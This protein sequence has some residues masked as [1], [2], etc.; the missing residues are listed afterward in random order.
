MIAI[1][2]TANRLVFCFVGTQCLVCCFL[3]FL[4]PNLTTA[5]LAMLTGLITRCVVVSMLVCGARPKYK[6]GQGPDLQKFQVQLEF[7]LSLS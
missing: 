3:L 5:Y 4:G 1:P 6:E 2:K 7:F